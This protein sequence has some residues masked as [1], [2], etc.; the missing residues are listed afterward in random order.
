MI[1]Y[2]RTLAS[3]RKT[4]TN[5]RGKVRIQQADP[6]LQSG[7]YTRRW[8]LPRRP[9]YWGLPYA[10]TKRQL[11]VTILP[12]ADAR[13]RR[14][15][16]RRF[17]HSFGGFN[18]VA[19]AYARCATLDWIRV[20]ALPISKVLRALDCSSKQVARVTISKSALM[21]GACC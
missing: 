2:L 3:H 13:A 7:L 8:R 20:L 10:S 16:V 18:V 17:R 15:I 19:H 12:S 1:L 5:C 21:R 4:P 14:K 11:A 6:L 9:C